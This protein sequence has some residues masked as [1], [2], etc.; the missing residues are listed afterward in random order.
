MMI[1]CLFFKS[2]GTVWVAK[3]LRKKLLQNDR[4]PQM[5]LIHTQVSRIVVMSELQSPRVLFFNVS[6]NL[7][8]LLFRIWIIPQC[9]KC[10]Y[11]LT[12][13]SEFSVCCS[14]D[15]LPFG[16]AVCMVLG[17]AAASFF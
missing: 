3:S 10:C 6:L 1:A 9:H 11:M 17:A 12:P 2:D 4:Q 13:F 8:D 7:S 16:Y 14:L 5:L 15:P